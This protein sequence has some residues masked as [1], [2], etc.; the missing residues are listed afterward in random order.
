MTQD[1]LIIL[2]LRII[3][4]ADV[5]CIAAFIADYTRMAPWWR[6]PIGRTIVIKDILL[7]LV[8]IPSILALFFTFDRFTSYVAAWV[9]VALLGALIPV[10]LWRIAV[11]RRVK[12][13]K[14]DEPPAGTEKKEGAA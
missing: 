7:I 10:M 14:T 12:A 13:G 6:N 1:Q 5:I 4:I 9:D 3:L 11:W 2:L 8:L